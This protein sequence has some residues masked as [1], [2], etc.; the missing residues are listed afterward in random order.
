MTRHKLLPILTAIPPSRPA[1]DLTPLDGPTATA[2][3]FDHIC[4]GKFRLIGPFIAPSD[5][6]TASPPPNL[7]TPQAGQIQK[8]P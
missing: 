4:R 1:G 3:W 5:P 2:R 7:S 6:G 8:S